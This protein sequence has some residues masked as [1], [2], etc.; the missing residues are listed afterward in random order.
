MAE[1]ET[2]TT[3]GRQNKYRMGGLIRSMDEVVAEVKAG[4]YIYLRHKPQHPGWVLSLQLKT[5]LDNLD[6]H[7][8]RFAVENE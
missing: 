1:T 6:R 7:E 3:D 2:T 8:I 5:L 4:R